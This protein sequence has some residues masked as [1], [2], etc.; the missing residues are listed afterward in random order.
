[1]KKKEKKGSCAICGEHKKLSFEHVPPKSAFNDKLIFMQSYDH[2][3]NDNSPL[4]GKKNRSQR[5]FGGHTLCEK[6]NNTTGDWYAKD[7]VEFARQGMKIIN[8]LPGNSYHIKGLYNI[9]PLNV[10]K[11][12]LTMFMSADKSG[13]LQS[14]PELVEFILNKEKTKIPE[15]YG[16]YLYSTLSTKKRMCGYTVIYKP[17]LGVQKWA[18][19][20]FQPFGY[21]LTE[22]SEPANKDMLN[23]SAFGDLKYGQIMK[24]EIT[25][26]Y[27]NIDSPWIG[28]YK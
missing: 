14:Q 22:E 9:K 27:L 18:E 6:C 21:L 25:T 11:Q 2:F 4:F 7:F 17:T 16:I 15:K 28:T 19:I 24:I 8:S 1:M 5:G 3:A 20:N 12:I 13:H 26:A 10:I 23:I